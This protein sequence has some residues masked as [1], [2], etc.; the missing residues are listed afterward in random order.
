MFTCSM[1]K[2]H[3]TPSRI[4]NLFPFQTPTD[5]RYELTSLRRRCTST[6]KHVTKHSPM[7]SI[8]RS[9][10]ITIFVLE[11][12]PERCLLSVHFSLSL[13]RP[14]SVN[15][16]SDRRVLLSAPRRGKATLSKPP[17]TRRAEG[18][19]LSAACTALLVLGGA[20]Q[21]H[22]NGGRQSVRH[23]DAVTLPGDV[24]RIQIDVKTS[25]A[26]TLRFCRAR[27]QS[28]NHRRFI[29]LAVLPYFHLDVF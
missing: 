15:P 27:R 16:A 17:V 25:V 4:H 21:T 5:R 19:Q 13:C 29:H 23:T 28:T 6:R 8:G 7:A 2:T 11:V 24:W 1:Q 3:I 22:F 20:T 10:Q 12:N 9:V 14:R 26:I 18:S